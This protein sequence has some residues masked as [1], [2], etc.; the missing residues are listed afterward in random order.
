MVSWFFW[1]VH[2]LCLPC[3]IAIFLVIESM[4]WV[5]FQ[6]Y[7]PLRQCFF[8][9]SVCFQLC[10]MWNQTRYFKKLKVLIWLWL[11]LCQWT[12][13]WKY[14]KKT[15][16]HKYTQRRREKYSQW[17]SLYLPTS[18]YWFHSIFKAERTFPHSSMPSP[19]LLNLPTILC[20]LSIT[21][22]FAFPFDLICFLYLILFSCMHALHFSEPDL[23]SVWFKLLWELFTVA[24]TANDF[25]I[26]I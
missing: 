26:W 9:F 6:P 19:F 18:L 11:G 15:H 20:D 25:I 2:T 22:L 4:W 14:P 13:V 7:I 23:T 5:C 12:N 8:A 21:T 17:D 24:Q 16:I 1:F 3:S 10:A